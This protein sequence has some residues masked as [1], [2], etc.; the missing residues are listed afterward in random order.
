M[1]F[2]RFS[3]LDSN[4]TNTAPLNITDLCAAYNGV[5][6]CTGSPTNW[7]LFYLFVINTLI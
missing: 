2:P 3:V 1:V 5:S 4:V 6:F 7:S